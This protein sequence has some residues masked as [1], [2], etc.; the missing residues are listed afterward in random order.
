MGA[1]GLTIIILG[2]SA[3]AGER[4]GLEEAEGLL[5]GPEFDLPQALRA[6][7]I[8]ENLLPQATAERTNVLTRLAQ[9]CFILGEVREKA[10][11]ERYFNQGRGYAE[12]LCQEQPDWADGHYWLALNLCG[13]VDARGAKEGFRLLPTIIRELE[14]T[15]SIDAAYDQAG[16]H[17][18]LGR[19]YYEAPPWPLSVGDL[20][21]SLGHLTA[22]VR[23]APENST[24]HLYLAET[25]F[26]LGKKDAAR[27]ELERVLKSTHHAIRPQGLKDDHQEAQR[28]LKE[29][30]I[31]GGRILRHTPLARAD[32]GAEKS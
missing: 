3:L 6:L 11:K 10:Q 9:V 29:W 15:L 5:T 13:L 19:I 30:A 28:L 21:K 26:R 23:I 12:V 7:E 16:A 2:S 1:V 4:A 20:H 27:Q 31:S 32:Y 14:R 17:R 22:A 8:Y 24:N 25:L 18:V